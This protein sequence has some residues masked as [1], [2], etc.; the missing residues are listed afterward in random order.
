MNFFSLFQ[1]LFNEETDPEV[2]YWTLRTDNELWK[3]GVYVS[4]TS[5]L[6]SKKLFNVFFQSIHVHPSLHSENKANPKA[7]NVQCP[8]ANYTSGKAFPKSISIQ[9][10]ALPK[11]MKHTTHNIPTNST[12][13][14]FCKANHQGLSI[15]KKD[16]KKVLS[17]NS[18]ALESGQLPHWQNTCL[19]LF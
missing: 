6:Q 15:N 3:Q 11:S 12:R 4:V 1:R 13:N 19:M 7:S 5:L 10:I 2:K 18:I 8:P 16:T 17:H 9:H 14:P